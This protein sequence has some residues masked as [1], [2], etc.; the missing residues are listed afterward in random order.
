VS[1]A[2]P[3]DRAALETDALDPA[4][5]VATGFPS[6]LPDLVPGVGVG[7]A[8]AALQRESDPALAALLARD[9]RPLLPRWPVTDVLAMAALE[10]DDPVSV[11]VLFEADHGAP[12]VC[13]L[14][15]RR[16]D[17]IRTERVSSGPSDISIATR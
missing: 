12:H 4:G 3:A 5:R 9:P 15:V 14:R 7:I 8:E 16:D 10:E 11:L 2:V 17:E 1:G 13:Q 6:P